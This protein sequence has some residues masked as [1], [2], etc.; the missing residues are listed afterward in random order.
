MSFR[1]AFL[2]L[3]LLLMCAS[4]CFANDCELSDSETNL[5]TQITSV[6]DDK[7]YLAPETFCIT[8]DQILVEFEGQL[9]SVGNI[10][11]VSNGFYIS[12]EEML[13]A[14]G[15]KQDTWKCRW[16]GRSNDMKDRWCA[17]CGRGWAE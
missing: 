1:N 3:S 9:L 12:V 15:K 2:I 14:I 6:L 4:N 13:A 10:S 17:R 7:V 16:C 11:V 5:C 8:Q